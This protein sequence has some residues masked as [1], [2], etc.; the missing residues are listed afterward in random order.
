MKERATVWGD[1]MA[2]CALWCVSRAF[3][4]CIQHYSTRTI[5]Q[6]GCIHRANMARM[7]WS[8]VSSWAC[9]RANTATKCPESLM[10]RNRPCWLLL[11]RA[12]STKPYPLDKPYASSFAS[13]SPPSIPHC[14]AQ[15]HSQMTYSR[16]TC[17]AVCWRISAQNFSKSCIWWEAILSSHSLMSTIGIWPFKFFTTPII[18]WNFAAISY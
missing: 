12:Q 15:T 18:V 4:S 2:C 8:T 11:S 7:L 13:C 3:T 5:H 6:T 17:L 10:T 14:S 1:S 9:S 16:L